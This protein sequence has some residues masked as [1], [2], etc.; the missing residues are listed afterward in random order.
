MSENYKVCDVLLVWEKETE[1]Y[2][3]KNLQITFK[4]FLKIQLYYN[5]NPKDLDSVTM[6]YVQTNFE[7]LKG[8]YKISLQNIIELAA[9]QFFINY[10][11]ISD[12]D[13]RRHVS[14]ELKTAVPCK[15]F[16]HIKDEEITVDK[17][18]D[19]YSKLNFKSKLEAKNKYLDIMKKMNYGKLPNLLVFF[20]NNTILNTQIHKK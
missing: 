7:V 10:G 5:Y 18:I 1:E 13:I 19:E 15:K 8:L 12:D 2:I 3:K 20:L 9:L 4:I 16:F 11:K 14:T 17:I 6:H